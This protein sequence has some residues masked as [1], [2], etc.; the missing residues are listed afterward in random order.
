MYTAQLWDPKNAQVLFSSSPSQQNWA[1]LFHELRLWWKD[2]AGSLLFLLLQLQW[3]FYTD[4]LFG[5]T[6]QR[7]VTEGMLTW[8]KRINELGKKKRTFPNLEHHF[9]K[10]VGIVILKCLPY[11]LWQSWGH[12]YIFR[13]EQILWEGISCYFVY[14]NVIKNFIIVIFKIIIFY[15]LDKLKKIIWRGKY[16]SIELYSETLLFLCLYPSVKTHWLGRQFGLITGAWKQETRC[17]V[18]IIMWL[19]ARNSTFLCLGF[20]PFFFWEMDINQ[21]VSLVISHGG[22]GTKRRWVD[23]KNLDKNILI[24]AKIL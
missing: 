3:F 12:F 18:S 11:F 10:L 6:L 13:N 4:W 17:M 1:D 7:F 23:E 19:W 24:I 5:S 22:N 8:V 15:Y 9:Q 2:S 16:L 21:Y 14:R 20:L